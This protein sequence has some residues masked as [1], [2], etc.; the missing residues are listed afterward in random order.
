MPR[1][2]AANF[3]RSNI[4]RLF[5]ASQNFAMFSP[6]GFWCLILHEGPRLPFARSPYSGLASWNNRHSGG[7]LAKNC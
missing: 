5:F 3:E 4:L 2:N 7:A 6:E 1:V